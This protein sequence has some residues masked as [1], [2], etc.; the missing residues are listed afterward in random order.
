LPLCVGLVEVKD[1]P[2]MA[3]QRQALWMTLAE[4]LKQSS[5]E[6]DVIAHFK[7]PK[8]PFGC[9]LVTTGPKQA[10]EI[11]Q[12]LSQNLAL[13]N[14]PFPVRL[15]FGNFIPK[16]NQPDELLEK[17]REALNHA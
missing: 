5:R 1:P 8:T 6:M 17:A 9:L 11:R 10:E 14:L 16:M 13:L 15:G 3:A 4:S 12:K 2:Q 7:D